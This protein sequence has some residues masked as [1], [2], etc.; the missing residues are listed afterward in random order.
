MRRLGRDGWVSLGRGRSQVYKN[1]EKKGEEEGSVVGGER[2]ERAFKADE[3][4]Q[5]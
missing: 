5:L 1:K 2:M 4:G 3:D